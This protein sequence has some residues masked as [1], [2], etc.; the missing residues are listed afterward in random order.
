M[1]FSRG[2]AEAQRRD[3]RREGKKGRRKEIELICA[4]L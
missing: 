1:Q 4:Y 2:D 3:R